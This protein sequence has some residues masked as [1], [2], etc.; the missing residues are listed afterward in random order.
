MWTACLTINETRYNF[1]VNAKNFHSSGVLNRRLAP[2]QK[3]AYNQP[4]E[5]HPL[6]TPTNFC[7]SNGTTNILSTVIYSTKNYQISVV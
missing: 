7:F 2:S 3:D 5:K 1:I 6:V 4:Y